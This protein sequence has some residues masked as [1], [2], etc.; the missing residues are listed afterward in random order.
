MSRKTKR[1]IF[2]FIILAALAGAVILLWPNTSVAPVNKD[3]ESADISRTVSA[4]EAVEEQKD[5]AQ[6]SA[7][8]LMYHHVGSLPEK[9]DTIRKGLTV[10][11]EE[12]ES[13]VKYLVDN[14]YQVMSFAKLDTLISQ[15]KVPKK[16]VIL[17]FDDGYDDNYNDALPIMKKYSVSGTF[18]IISNKV[19]SSEYM[20]QDQLKGLILAGNEIGSHSVSHPSLEKYKGQALEKE[21]TKSK[22][23]LEKMTGGKII[24]FCYPA[25]K[26]NDDTVKAVK[27]AGYKYAVTTVSSNGII[28]LDNP[29]TIPRFRISTGRNIE[30]LLK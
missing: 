21:L 12:F 16:L 24:S 8:V 18:F 20:N 29:F 17:T 22:E 7:S 19:D 30:V 27:D 6:I 14:D 26:Y 10:S 23:D 1:N 13:H 5:S 9:A 15:K 3:A 11:A 25:G 4:T 28:D 2:S